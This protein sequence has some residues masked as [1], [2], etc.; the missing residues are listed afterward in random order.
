MV[1]FVL[2]VMT[3]LYLLWTVMNGCICFDCHDVVVFA[4]DCH[5]VVVFI[6]TVMAWLYLL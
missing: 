6:V 4:V 5:D 3:W 1:V 2:T